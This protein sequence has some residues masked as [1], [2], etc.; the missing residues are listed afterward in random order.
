MF[1]TTILKFLYK[2]SVLR[3]ILITLTGLFFMLTY[4]MYY[5]VISKELLLLYFIYKFR[6]YFHKKFNK[7]NIF[8]HLLSFYELINKN[9]I[10]N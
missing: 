7:Y 4:N 8:Y 1:L 3:I 2:I 6:E 9:I 10:Q 5:L